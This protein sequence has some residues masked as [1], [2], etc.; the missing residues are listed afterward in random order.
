MKPA[1]SKL[2]AKTDHPEVSKPQKQGALKTRSVRRDMLVKANTEH[3]NPQGH[4]Y[5]SSSY[6]QVTSGLHGQSLQCPE[7][8][9]C[10][11]R[12]IEVYPPVLFSNIRT[13]TPICQ[14]M[15][16]IPITHNAEEVY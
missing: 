13:A 6:P 14:V 11:T 10:N 7:S 9:Q 12:L 15:S 1:E 8:E 4:G 16:I 5:M 3:C 2:K